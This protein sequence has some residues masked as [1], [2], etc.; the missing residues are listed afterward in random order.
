MTHSTHFYLPLYGVRHMVKDHADSERGNLL[1]PHGLLFPISTRVLLYTS[2]HRQDNTY[3]ILCYTSHGALAGTR[4]SLMGPPWKDQS[5][6]SSHY[7]QTLL[8]RSYISLPDSSKALI[9][10]QLEHFNQFFKK[11]SRW[12]ISAFNKT[13]GVCAHDKRAWTWTGH[14]HENKCK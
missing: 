5:N 14:N 9:W 11:H 4:N 3:D 13:W 7:E 6:D 10:Y 2:S 12:K 8:L 1:A